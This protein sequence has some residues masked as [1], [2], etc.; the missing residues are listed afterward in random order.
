MSQ[1]IYD[2]KQFYPLSLTL[3]IGNVLSLNVDLLDLSL[4]LSISFKFVKKKKKKKNYPQF[5]L[6]HVE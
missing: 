5:P 6:S 1:I 2:W 3:F 4:I